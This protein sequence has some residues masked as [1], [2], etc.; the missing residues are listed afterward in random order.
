[1]LFDLPLIDN[2]FYV[3]LKVLLSWPVQKLKVLFIWPVQKLKE[4][5]RWPVQLIQI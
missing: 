3:R 5:F 2:D 1:M 4:L